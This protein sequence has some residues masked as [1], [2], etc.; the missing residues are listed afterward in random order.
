MYAIL[1]PPMRIGLI[2]TE[3]YVNENRRISYGTEP[4]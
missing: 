3:R 2:P 4:G 1:K